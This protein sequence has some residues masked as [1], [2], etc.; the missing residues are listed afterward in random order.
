MTNIATERHVSES[1]RGFSV[2]FEASSSS[3]TAQ[4]LAAHVKAE[5]DKERKERDDEDQWRRWWHQSTYLNLDTNGD[6]DL[7]MQC[8]EVMGV[9]M[10]FRKKKS[11][12]R[13]LQKTGLEDFDE[14][15]PPTIHTLKKVVRGLEKKREDSAGTLWARTRANMTAFANSM[16]GHKQLFSLF[17]SENIYTSV[18]SGVVSTI[19]LTC[20]N[21]KR[22]AEGFS[23]GFRHI[24][25]N[26]EYLFLS[27]RSLN[28]THARKAVAN[29][30]V[31]VFKFLCYAMNWQASRLNR[32]TSAMQ[33]TFYNDHI[34]THVDEIDRL[35]RLVNRE[36]NRQTHEG[37]VDLLEMGSTLNS[38]AQ[39][40]STA[41][42]FRKNDVVQVNMSF[43]GA[44]E[45]FSRLGYDATHCLTA[46][47]QQYDYDVL[48]VA[49]RRRGPDDASGQSHEQLNEQPAD[50]LGSTTKS[51]DCGPIDSGTDLETGDEESST[52]ISGPVLNYYVREDLEL[53]VHS[54]RPFANNGLEEATRFARQDP[55]QRFPS[56]VMNDI[57]QWLKANTSSLL[58]VEGPAFPSDLS[59]VALRVWAVI[60]G[61]WIPSICFFDQQ[62]YPDQ[63]QAGVREA[64]TICL[65]YSLIGQLINQLPSVI[66]T[67]YIM[68]AAYFGGL[69]GSWASSQFA[70]EVISRLL[71][72]A[73]PSLVLVIHGLEALEGRRTQSIIS[74]LVDIIR[75]QSSLTVVKA[76]FSTN[77][78]SQ[79]LGNK[80]T[81]TE[82][83]NAVRM[84]Q[85]GP[86][87]SLPGGSY[88]D[89]IFS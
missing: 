4:A 63:H 30:Y 14:S 36:M 35:A 77:G 59:P 80:M 44:S 70:L 12:K 55:G 24:S 6:D 26:L 67:E 84:G 65:L 69:D 16:D 54:I 1:I 46:A 43:E 76:F 58:W 57:Q 20:V 11:I 31:E 49:F 37:V 79:V 2:A 88:L 83:I 73:P 52:D 45:A 56:E 9:W 8:K 62:H 34:K 39:Q 21:Y 42:R 17:P 13:I 50:S 25:D 68:D 7:L 38:A 66:E 28:T 87:R 29:A 60:A 74:Q 40:K 27:E 75:E 78:M 10:V 89:E 61:A 64:G 53:F 81:G 72:Y 19:I 18:L 85:A 23:K 48:M 22:V 86:S 82:R 5:A 3:D 71:G 32:V 15:K 33:N 51:A 41:N 47:E